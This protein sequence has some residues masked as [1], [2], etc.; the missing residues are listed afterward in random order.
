MQVA[1]DRDPR[2]TVLS[3]NGVGAFETGN[4]ERSSQDARWQHTFP[5]RFA[6]LRAPFHTF[7]EDVEGVV[8]VIF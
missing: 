8:Q 7:V 5:L 6:V 2:A 3:F 4:D 1:S